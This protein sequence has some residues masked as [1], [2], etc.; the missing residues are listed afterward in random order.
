[1]KVFRKN[2]Y[3]L[4][5]RLYQDT[6]PYPNE[7]NPQSIKHIS[8]RGDI[9]TKNDFL[10]FPNVTELTLLDYLNPSLHSISTILD[11]LMPLTKLSKLTIQYRDLCISQLID[12]LYFSPNIQLI[13]LESSIS[14]SKISLISI[15]QT[16]TF[17]TIFNDN[18]IQNMIFKKDSTVESVRLF[19]KLCPRLEQMTID[20]N[21]YDR[22]MVMKLIENDLH[23]SHVPFLCFLNIGN[24]SQW[25]IELYLSKHYSI[26]SVSQHLYIWS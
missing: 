4:N 12:L 6:Y 1:M 17:Q 16:Q 2:H 14:F 13:I 24:T 26:K 18:K 23:D 20:L 10:Y 11:R 22:T 5:H 19:Y 15:Q 3:I 8:I 21:R 7:I 25:G 9:T